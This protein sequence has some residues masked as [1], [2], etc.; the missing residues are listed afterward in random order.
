MGA[1]LY[2]CLSLAGRETD[3]LTHVL[4][5]EPFETIPEFYFPGRPGGPLSD[6]GGSPHAASAAR[7]ELADVPFVPLRNLFVRDLGKRVGTFSRL[8]ETCREQVRTRAGRTLRIEVDTGRCRLKVNGHEVAPS[9]REHVVILFLATRAKRE[10]GGFPDYMNAVEPLNA[11]QQKLRANRP[12]RILT[13]WR[14]DP[15]LNQAFAEEDLRKLVHSLKTKRRQRGG[16]AA[17]LA[18]CLPE[19]GRFSLELEPALVF[20]K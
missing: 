20:L 16:D 5:S 12:P 18:A 1:L 17:L 19:K 6:R 9:A 13:D 14:H 7:L 10:E 15:R 4:V 8:I 11:F 3:R 2:A